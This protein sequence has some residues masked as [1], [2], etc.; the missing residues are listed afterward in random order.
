MHTVTFKKWSLTKLN[1]AFGL[2][3]VWNLPLMQDWEA[4][5]C[6]VT[7]FEKE[8]LLKLQHSLIHGGRAWNETELQG[9]FISPIIMLADIE[10]E[11]IG[12]F[13]ERNL[14]A[15][16]GNYELSGIVDGMIATGRGEPEIPLFCLHEYKRS[17]HASSP[18]AQVLVAMLVAREQNNN[19]KP[20]YG[21]FVTGLIWNFVILN[22]NEYCISRE[23]RTVDNEL[24]SIFAM[25]K[26]LKVIIKTNLLQ[27]NV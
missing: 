6:E 27:Y 7:A 24:F 10:N 3:E 18:D 17:K 22:G 16:I 20:I 13:L 15:T 25:L 9:K 11:Q 23:Y 14:A 26:A 12:Y 21:L 1:H 5:K 8:Y 19:N 4:S 2:K